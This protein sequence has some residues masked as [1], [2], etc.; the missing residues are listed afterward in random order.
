MIA[1]TLPAARVVRSVAVMSFL[2]GAIGIDQ[3]EPVAR[4]TVRDAAGGAQSGELRAGAHTA[5]WAW[6]RADVAAVVRHRRAP[7]A[8]PFPMPGGREGMGNKYVGIV[9]LPAP[10]EAV[11]VEVQSVARQA[12]LQLS[13]ISLLDPPGE[14]SPLSL[15][16]LL[17]E[18]PERWARRVSLS[19]PLRP[20]TAPALLGGAWLQGVL[21]V[22]RG[23]TRPSVVHAEVLE[24]LH[25]LPAAWFV[26]RTLAVDEATALA[27]VRTA[28][29]PDGAPFDP[30]A[31]ALVEQA[32]GRDFGPGDPSATAVVVAR[33]PQRLVLATR[34]AAPGFLVVS[35]LAYPG[36]T[37]EVDGAP[38]S[39]LR[40]NGMLRGLALAAG[41]HRVEF[42]YRPLSVRLGLALAGATLLAFAAAGVWGR[43]TAAFP[44]PHDW[45]E[46]ARVRGP[47]SGL[48]ASRNGSLTPTLSRR[49]CGRGSQVTPRTRRTPP[50]SPR[51]RPPR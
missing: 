25:V 3:D 26:P 20:D 18:R 50:P 9:T 51:R 1:F 8:E 19:Y 38:V 7:I 45:R 12:V 31:V 40:T 11:R 10:V 16:H 42:V 27:S 34:S 30:R 15:A 46:R 21:G 13:R 43:G 44:L 37:A 49:S 41:A 23:P 5:E 28:R 36:W 33:A 14:P 39:I 48:G 17:L 24:N 2:G 32:P 4:I 47:C 22:A 6:D 35:E 29:L